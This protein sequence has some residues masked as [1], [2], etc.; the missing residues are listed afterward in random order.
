MLVRETAG[1]L[2]EVHAAVVACVFDLRLVAGEELARRAI[3]IGLLPLAAF[4]DPAGEL[5]GVE[6]RIAAVSDGGERLVFEREERRVRTLRRPRW[7]PRA[8]SRA[9]ALEVP[10]AEQPHDVDVMRRLLDSVSTLSRNQAIGTPAYMAPEQEQG[11]FRKEI[12]LEGRAVTAVAVTPDGSQA[13]L[14]VATADAKDKKTL[15]TLALWE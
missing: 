7:I 6:V 11:I 14:G 8:G 13:L 9:H 1:R 5:V 10:A 12:S 15:H 4:A 3:G 2:G